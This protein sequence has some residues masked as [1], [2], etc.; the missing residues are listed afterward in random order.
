MKFGVKTGQSG[1]T[2]EELAAIWSKSDELGF[3]SAWLHDHLMP[4]TL[5]DGASEP[6][7][8]AYT[9]L[10]ALARETRRIRLGTMVTCAGYRN[11]A[12][13]AKIGATI[14]SISGG[15]F[16]MGIG[17][18]WFEG[19]YRAYGYDFPSI[20]ERVG[21]L[22]ET[23]KILR[24]M[25]TEDSPSFTGKYY[26]IVNPACNPKP[27]QRELPIWVGISTG[28]RTLPRFAVELADG[29]N[30]TAGPSLCGQIIEKAE[31]VRRAIGR[32][33]KT[34]TY[35]AQPFLLIGSDSEIDDIVGEEARASGLSPQD[36]LGRLR[37]KDC[38]IGTPELCA[39]RLRDYGDAGVDYLIPTIIGARLLWPLE[40]I[41]DKLLPLL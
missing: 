15:R 23:L 29:L 17:T 8:E 19:E 24:Q 38:V 18:G 41:R 21:R 27:I 7:L 1:Y 4:V 34:V 12:Y 26:K 36:Y 30:T 16:I 3:E 5:V 10:A 37:G 14:D 11:P 22:R 13:L 31:E 2:Y 32:N 35:S 6:C 40:T 33:R 20:P 28:T 39:Q 25:W 9:T